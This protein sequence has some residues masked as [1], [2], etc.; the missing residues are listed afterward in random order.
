RFSTSDSPCNH[1]STIMVAPPV[2]WC[3]RPPRRSRIMG[4]YRMGLGALRLIV[5]VVLSVTVTITA[6]P[7]SRFALV[8]AADK[9]GG[10]I[11][12]LV[13]DDFVVEDG[14]MRAEVMSVTPASYPVAVIVDTSSFARSDFHQIREAV[15]Q[16]VGSLS[17]RDLA[18]YATGMVPKRRVEFTR[19]LGHLETSI[20]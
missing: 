17:G 11:F 2:P 14:G 18:L 12:G 9:D 16:F 7:E 10:Q 1:F 19:D 15:H 4:A 20:V 3:G 13:A 5:P 6:A 8:S